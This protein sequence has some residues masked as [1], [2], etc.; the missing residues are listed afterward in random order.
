MS[1]KVF[2]INSNITVK[3]KSSEKV[4]V[5]VENVLLVFVHLCVGIEMSLLSLIFY[6]LGDVHFATCVPIMCR[7]RRQDLIKIS[8]DKDLI[9][10]SLTDS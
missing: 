3:L 6:E 2:L 5:L 7:H 9:G 1:L 10:A 4:K 8:A